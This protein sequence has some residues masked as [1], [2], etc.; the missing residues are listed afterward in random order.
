MQ[1][2]WKSKDFNAYL[3]YIINKSDKSQKEEL[4]WDNRYRAKICNE[5]NGKK[6]EIIKCT[7]IDEEYPKSDC[8]RIQICGGRQDEK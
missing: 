4:I 7:Y 6:K 2:I 8:I 5:G 3:W 1:A